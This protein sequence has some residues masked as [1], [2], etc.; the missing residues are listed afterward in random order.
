MQRRN[1]NLLLFQD[2]LS[3][4][5]LSSPLCPTTALCKCFNYYAIVFVKSHLIRNILCLCVSSNLSD[6]GLVVVSARG[7]F[8][9]SPAIFSSFHF[10]NALI[11]RGS[12]ASATLSLSLQFLEDEMHEAA[13]SS[14]VHC[15]R[16]LRGQGTA[17]AKA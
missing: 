3:S 4:Q 8:D 16:S 5:S 1:C 10:F 9:K 13:G 6:F 12:L 11:I 15:I 2:H 7:G 14:L 17:E